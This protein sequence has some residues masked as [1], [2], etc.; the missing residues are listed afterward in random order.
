MLMRFEKLWERRAPIVHDGEGRR[1][2]GEM[3]CRRRDGLP[4]SP[5]G[6]IEKGDGRRY[7]IGRTEKRLTGEWGDGSEPAFAFV[8]SDGFFHT[9]GECPL[10]GETQI[11]A[12]GFYIAQ[13]VA[14]TQ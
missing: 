14:L 8:P 10:R 2:E 13:P 4:T 12:G 3:T 5:R 9:G 11:A 1:T 7:A 6:S